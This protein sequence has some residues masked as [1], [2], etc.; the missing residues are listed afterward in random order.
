MKK[1]LDNIQSIE[2]G[3]IGKINRDMIEDV[4]ITREFNSEY[5]DFKVSLKNGINISG[6]TQLTSFKMFQ[7]QLVEIQL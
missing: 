5:V 7:Y 4:E 3:F 1:N 6:N 2:I